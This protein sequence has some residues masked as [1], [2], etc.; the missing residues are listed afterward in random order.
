M[1]RAPPKMTMVELGPRQRVLLAETS[2]DV[3]NIAAGAMIFGQFLGEH[4]FS[5]LVAVGG[6]VLWIFFVIFAVSLIGREQP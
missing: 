1:R 5:P 3:A 6:V 2:R 4:A